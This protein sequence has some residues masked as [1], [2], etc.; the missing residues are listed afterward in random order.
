MGETLK[1]FEAEIKE[2]VQWERSQEFNLRI[3]E[4]HK[5]QFSDFLRYFAYPEKRDIK[6]DQLIWNSFVLETIYLWDEL[7]K[8]KIRKIL[9][10]CAPKYLLNYS[11]YE[12][13]E[14]R[15]IEEKHF[16]VEIPK[17]AWDNFWLIADIFKK[18]Y[19][20]PEYNYNTYF[21]PKKEK[22]I[23][24]FDRK[25]IR[26]HD[27]IDTKPGKVVP[28]SPFHW[29][30][31]VLMVL[32]SFVTDV[33][34]MLWANTAGVSGSSLIAGYVTIAT[35]T[36]Y[37]SK[38]DGLDSDRNKKFIDI[39]KERLAKGEVTDAQFEKLKKTIENS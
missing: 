16:P 1:Q 26:I 6:T 21:N 2:D 30:L 17:D 33:N 37:Q 20:I 31:P 9:A 19:L 15:E 13:K 14:F 35:A 5:K 10:R 3:L 8:S 12:D 28:L 4:L 7:Y 29:G 36:I 25:K 39:L 11:Y 32:G 38:H 27:L 34:S 24:L 18:D 23:P 22:P